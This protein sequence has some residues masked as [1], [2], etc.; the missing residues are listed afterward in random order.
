MAK[1]N[2]GANKGTTGTANP[3]DNGANDQ[4]SKK[5]P[6]PFTADQ[7]ESAA[8]DLIIDVNGVKVKVPV[9]M[10]STGSF[11]W[12]ESK[13]IDVT[14]QVGDDDDETVDVKCQFQCQFIVVNSKEAPRS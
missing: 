7:F 11:G 4:A 12:Y 10:F 5:T 13:K 3:N 8:K 9:K 6:C 2:K 14:V 1:G